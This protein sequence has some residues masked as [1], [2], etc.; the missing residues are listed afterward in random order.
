MNSIKEREISLKNKI[1][2]LSRADEWRYKNK[3]LMLEW[4]NVALR[5]LY[6]KY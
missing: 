4:L 6:L 1:C 3:K 2:E 5:N